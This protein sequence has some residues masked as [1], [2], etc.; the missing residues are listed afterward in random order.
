MENQ[1]IVE[2]QP[3]LEMPETKKSY[4]VLAVIISVIVT[5]AVV[6]GGV[7]FWQNQ[8]QSKLSGEIANLQ[9]DIDQLKQQAEN[10]QA[11]SQDNSQD[12]GTKYYEYKLQ[13]QYDKWDQHLIRRNRQTGEGMVV[14][15]SI[16]EALP[17]L[18]A[19][20]NLLLYIFAQPENSE[21]V[22]F[23][24]A[25]VDTNN[26][27]GDLYSFSTA[28][29]KFT[30]MKVND[31]YSGF[32]GG[33]ALSPDQTKFVWVP[34]AQDESG[35][36]QMMYLI[37]LIND[38]YSTVVNLSGNETFNAGLYAMSSYFEVSW[39]NDEKIKYAVFDQSKKGEGFDPY[40]EATRRSI[41]IGY[42]EVTP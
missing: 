1:P 36:A 14:I 38:T 3:V 15:D 5:A 24:S 22:I 19:E 16:K 34:D 25:L 33:F 23:K 6:G 7:Y 13:T 18:K 9:N 4:T 12:F 11:T 28:D 35:K 8:L 27:G 20:F 30:K 37:D 17:E 29:S 42:R 10:S 40:S 39:V 32:F 2:S 31:V 41:F 26:P 21:V